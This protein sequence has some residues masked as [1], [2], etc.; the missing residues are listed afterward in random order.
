MNT[1]ATIFELELIVNGNDWIEY[2]FEADSERT[3]LV[4]LG[5]DYEEQVDCLLL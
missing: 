5:T 2:G 4:S 1:E 3:L